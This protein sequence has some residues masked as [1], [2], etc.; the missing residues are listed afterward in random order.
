MDK[1]KSIVMTKELDEQSHK[2]AVQ[3]VN[4]VNRLAGLSQ[5]LTDLIYYRKKLTQF[6]KD[7]CRSLFIEV[8]ECQFQQTEFVRMMDEAQGRRGL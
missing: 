4:I 1:K 7:V 5:A 2:V 6:Q 8:M 3:A